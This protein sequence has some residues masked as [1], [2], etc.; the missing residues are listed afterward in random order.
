MV[1]ELRLLILS[2]IHGDY[3]NLYKITE[4]ERFDELIILGDLFSYGYECNKDEE[5]YIINLLQKYKN[6]LILI[7][8]NCDIFINY[9]TIGLQF[10]DVITLPFNKHLVTFTHGDRYSRGFLPEYHGDIFISGHTHIPMIIKE[11]GI[12]YANPGSIGK[13]RGGSRKSYIIFDNDKIIIKDINGNT[14]KEML[15]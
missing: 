14:Q 5:E 11:R 2:D 1:I 6:K 15:V 13:P 10:Y 8:G 12:I 7:K 9:E 4:N 3:K